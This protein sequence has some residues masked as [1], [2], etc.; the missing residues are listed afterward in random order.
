[1]TTPSERSRC[2]PTPDWGYLSFAGTLPEHRGKGAQSILL[3][4]RI[5]HARELGC[6]LVV[7]ETGDR[8]ADLPSSSYRNLIRA[9]FDERH[10]VENWIRRAP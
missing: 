4:G 7:T 3:A 8:R 10:V 1:M 9:G 2:T 6:R 5:R